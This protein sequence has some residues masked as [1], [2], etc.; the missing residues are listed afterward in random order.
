MKRLIKELS[1][2]G[3]TLKQKAIVWYFIISFCLLASTA[4]APFWFLFL[5]VANFANA[6]GFHYR[7]THEIVRYGRLKYKTYRPY[8]GGIIRANRERTKPPDRSRRYQRPE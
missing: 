5:E 2:S 1:L 6:A 4:E 8:G 3:L 7:K